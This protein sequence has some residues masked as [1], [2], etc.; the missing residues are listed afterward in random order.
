[1]SAPCPRIRLPASATNA[2]GGAPTRRTA[3][4]AQADRRAPSATARCALGG[5][6]ACRG[7]ARACV[8]V[9]GVVRG[10]V[11]AAR[12]RCRLTP[13][14]VGVNNPSSPSFSAAL[15][16]RPRGASRTAKHGPIPTHSSAFHLSRV[17]SLPHPPNHPHHPPTHTT[18]DVAQRVPLLPP[19]L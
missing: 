15:V 1:M 11:C 16:L 13:S 18:T 9:C 10:V 8:C 6:P 2:W 19:V 4:S 3:T 14:P 12:P 17:A 5:F 7:P